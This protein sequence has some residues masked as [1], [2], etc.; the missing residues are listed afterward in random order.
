MANSIL[1]KPILLAG[2]ITISCEVAAGAT[3]NATV[4]VNVV[5]GSSFSI[6]DSIA[7]TVSNDDRNGRKNSA[8][9]IGYIV[10]TSLNTRKPARLNIKSYEDRIYDITISSSSPLANDS[11]MVEINNM[12]ILNIPE[13]HIITGVQEFIIEGI[14]L[15]PE[16]KNKGTLFGSA[17]ININYN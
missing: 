14:M 8:V 16:H 10:M 2:L 11:S 1:T 9:D 12:K 6:S 17:E 7:L 3:A 5:T 13:V 15:E 4:S